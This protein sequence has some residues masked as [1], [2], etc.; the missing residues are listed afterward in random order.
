M[1]RAI[2]RARDLSRRNV[3]IPEGTCL[4]Q[5]RTVMDIP[6]GG[7]F[8]HDGDADAED[9]WKRAQHKR[10]VEG[11]A[12]QLL[13]GAPVFWTGGSHDNGHVAIATGYGRGLDASVWSPGVPGTPTRWRKV[14]VGLIS[15]GWG[16][17][18]VGYTLDLNGHPV[19]DIERG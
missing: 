16:L 12:F 14:A 5:V 6:A 3:P 15:A 13:R 19:P 18:L 4:L 9:A 1:Y 17:Q 7:D 11:D 10:R 2:R 8:D